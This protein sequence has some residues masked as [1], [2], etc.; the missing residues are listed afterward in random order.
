MCLPPS[1]GKWKEKNQIK[2]TN[3]TAYSSR[4]DT[5]CDVNIPEF[6]AKK[7]IASWEALDK[8]FSE[9]YNQN[10][11][12]KFPKVPGINNTF[13]FCIFTSESSGYKTAYIMQL[14]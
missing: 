13:A 3:G 10:L 6:K 9:E 2:E 11:L 12:H 5:T 7:K 14:V 4:G 1:L 8:K